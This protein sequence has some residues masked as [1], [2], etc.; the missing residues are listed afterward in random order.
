[1]NTWLLICNTI[2]FDIRKA[3]T[4]LN[5]ITWPQLSEAKVDD[6]V[7]VY[8]TNPY[9]AILYC[10]KV[11][12]MDLYRMDSETLPY[13]SSP[14]FYESAQIYMRL[15]K[16]LE[17]P[18]GLITEQEI[19]IQK[20]SSLQSTAIISKEFEKFIQKKERL[21]KKRYDSKKSIKIG[22]L[23]GG[24]LTV[25]LILILKPLFVRNVVR[26]ETDGQ[27]LDASIETENYQTEEIEKSK[28]NQT[29][30][31]IAQN[32]IEDKLE[33]NCYTTTLL[34]G[35][36]ID[37]RLRH[38]DWGIDGRSK[39]IAWSVDDETIASI[40]ENGV[41]TAKAEG[42]CI[43]TAELEGEVD[44][45]EIVVVDVNSDD[46]A[47][48]EVEY[49]YISMNSGGKSDITISFCGNMPETYGAIAYYSSGLSLG[50]EWENLEN[51]QALLTIEESL[52]YEDEG[53]ITILAYDLNDPNYVV[54][55]KRIYI[56]IN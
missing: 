19:R 14:L 35:D 5:K 2:H 32:E 44:S 26:E 43:L 23:I 39:T 20:L 18:E 9:R 51:N 6:I 25:A 50:L 21:F 54:A 15:E 41:L 27:I 45:Q 7:Y 38:G 28:D 37:T 16:I 29:K 34:V 12:E 40:G 46:E 3:F 56:D 31:S 48:I 1:M 33:I 24:L 36:S 10:C 47:M 53:Y 4:E 49:E 13:V 8:V 22:I 17:Y 30:E 55:A 52:S 42:K 11:E